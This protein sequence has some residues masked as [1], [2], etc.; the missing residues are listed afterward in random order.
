MMSI[1]FVMSSIAFAQGSPLTPIGGLL[2]RLTLAV[3]FLWMA[4]LA[5]WSL[6]T[7]TTRES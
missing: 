1:L 6:M 7:P 4:L 5:L 2:K 3:G